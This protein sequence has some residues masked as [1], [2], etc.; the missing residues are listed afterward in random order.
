MCDFKESTDVF[1]YQNF[2]NYPIRAFSRDSLMKDSAGHILVERET[3][4]KIIIPQKFPL[5]DDIYGLPESIDDNRVFGK[6]PDYANCQ[7]PTI[8]PPDQADVMVVSLEYCLAVERM[9][10]YF[11]RSGRGLDAI[12]CQFYRDRFWLANP[13]YILNDEGKLEEVGS[14]L[15]K[16]MPPLLPADYN[17]YLNQNLYLPSLAAVQAALNFYKGSTNVKESEIEE[18]QKWFNER[19]KARA[20]TNTVSAE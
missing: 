1:S 10:S 20:G 13:V 14:Y 5:N 16:A 7:I 2:V 8:P 11:W 4:P 17:S 15:E 19:I 9:C 6:C 12:S 3:E 18:L